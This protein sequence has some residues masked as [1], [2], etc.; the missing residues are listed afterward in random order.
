MDEETVNQIEYTLTNGKME[1]F[2]QTESD[3]YR[4]VLLHKYG[5]VYIDAATI[6]VE[7]YDW[8]INI[9]DF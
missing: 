1:R 2:V 3:L 4:L 7:N 5:G 9:A 6:A 8:L